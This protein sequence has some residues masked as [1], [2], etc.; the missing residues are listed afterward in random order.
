MKSYWSRVGL[1]SN[2]PGALIER[3]NLDT[4]ADINSGRR[5]CEEIH[6]EDS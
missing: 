4:E 5:S 1:S 6:G 3:G 2:I